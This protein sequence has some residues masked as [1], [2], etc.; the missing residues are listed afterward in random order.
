MADNDLGGFLRQRREALRPE[1]VGLPVG[2]RR[3]TPGLRRSELAT[4]AGIS[5][6]YLTRLEQGRDRNPSPQVLGALADALR[7]SRDERAYLRYAAKS[8]SGD[9]APCAATDPPVLEVRSSLIGVLRALEP[10]PAVLLNRL[11]DVLAHT[12]A[13][14]RYAGPL[15]ILEGERPNLLRWVFTDPRARAAYPNW[16]ERADAHIAAVRVS[17]GPSDHHLGALAE[18]LAVLAGAAFTQRFEPAPI[19]MPGAFTE[20]VRHPEA[21]PLRFQVEQMA[22]EDERL[23]VHLPA[24][25]AT[26]Q[27]LDR[28]IGK[29]ALHSITTRSA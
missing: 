5:V 23:L 17:S 19:A 27:A 8:A 2:A 1:D 14:A 21:G 28:L 13:Y 16:D 9:P 25:S 15:G 18:E 20:T 10:V 24:D 7:L 11:S 12:D 26:E 22:T 3:R 6:E 29:G 4:L